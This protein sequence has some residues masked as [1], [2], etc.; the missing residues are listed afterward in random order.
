MDLPFSITEP[1][2]LIL[3]LA[4]PPVVWLGVLTARARPRDRSR[5]AASTVLRALILTFLALAIAGTQFIAS[6]GPLN[7][8]FLVDRSASVSEA[9]RQ[10]SFDY[11]RQAIET[12]GE[13]DRAAVVLF[14]ENA[15]LDRAL[16]ADTSW[17]ATGQEPSALATDIADAIQVGTALFPEGGAK[18]LVLLSDGLQTVGEARS[19]AAGEALSGIQLS[20]VPLGGTAENEVAVD[21]VVSPNSVPSGQQIPVRVLVKSNSARAAA[22]TLF[23]GETPVATQDMQL[24]AGDNVVSFTTEAREQG[25]HVL[26]ARVDSVDDRFSENNEALSFTIVKRPPTVLIVSGSDDDSLPLQNALEA[27]GIDVELVAPVAL[28]REPKNIGNYD[29]IVLANVS[30]ES[31]EVEG[32]AVLQS[33]VRDMGRGLIMIGGDLSYG[34]GGYTRSPIEEVLPVRMDVRT[35][36]ERASLAMTFVID[37]SGSMGR[38]HCG[39]N[40]QFSPSMRTEFGE[41]KI[42]LVK[43]A[44]GKAT[45]LLNSSDQVGVVAFDEQPTWLARLQPLAE[46]GEQRLEQLL[47]PVEAQGNTD[48]FAAL[49]QSVDSLK[50]SNAQLKHIV[51]LGDGWSKHADYGPLLAEMSASNIT[52][53]TVGVGDGADDLLLDLATR[54]G[55]RF[56]EANDVRDVPDVLLKE[57]IRL[58]GS[59]Y[60]EEAFTPAV[61]RASPIMSGI[62]TGAMPPLLGYNAT[63]VKPEAD[64]ILRSP[65]G[66]P[67]LAQWQYGL[68]RA[69]AWTS[70][71]KGQWAADWVT[72]PQFGR[73]V[74]QM[75]SWTLPR[76]DSIVLEASFAARPDSRGRG[77]EIA[78]R[79]DTVTA[80]GAP[81]NFLPTS[82]VIT[83][84]AGIT[85]TVEVAPRSPGVYDGVAHGL[86]P[87]AYAATVEQVDAE[88][89]ELVERL[90][91][92]FVVPYPSEYRLSEES[93]VGAQALMADLAQLGGGKVLEI[94]QPASAFSHDIS[95]E[96]RRLPLWPWL[97]LAAILLFP[98]D[99]AV[100]RVSLSPRELWRMLRGRVPE[101]G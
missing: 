50:A 46:L 30:A 11:V 74:G 10:A 79:V 47:Q 39:G 68:G 101:G 72:W 63:T 73:F 43:R 65:R 21:R 16:N 18:R 92:G 83:D 35:S 84:T 7:V 17:E 88:T 49:S 51:V 28:P 38:C 15:I 89:G 62:D 23:D 78:V 33:Y 5:I 22:V 100:R 93:A 98:L 99:V 29:A 20:V 53:S 6:G 19:I 45:A 27:S 31:L 95:P 70:D 87:G 44:I 8:V 82:L 61:A 91:T 90:E 3:L 52:L 32:Q 24:K 56:Y 34:A 12:M 77:Q 66:D 48:M 67:L 97:I 36:E 42:E 2:A 57:T 9:T 60:V 26:K 55:G 37:K 59:Y 76:Q 4:V 40:Q 94:S 1:R 25:F 41:S 85:T 81:R 58:A 86:S 80:T 64:L 54:G 13:D 71:A 75:V 69:V 14:G 96:P